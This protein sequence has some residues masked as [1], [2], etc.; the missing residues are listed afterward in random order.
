MEPLNMEPLTMMAI[1]SVIAGAMGATGSSMSAGASERMKKKELEE[2]EKKRKMDFITQSMDREQSA[3]V[4]LRK[5]NLQTAQSRAQI[6]QGIAQNI[7]LGA[8]GG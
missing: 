4:D 1:A 7:K 8:R 5:G 6:L 3:G 2:M